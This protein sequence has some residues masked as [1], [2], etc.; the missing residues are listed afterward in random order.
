[1]EWPVGSILQNCWGHS[2]VWGEW[3]CIPPSSYLFYMVV[4]SFT[5]SLTLLFYL[6]VNCFTM[7]LT[8]FFYMGVNCSTISLTLLHE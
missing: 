4:N 8:L 1:M 6:G 3:L 2:A 7:S 5:M